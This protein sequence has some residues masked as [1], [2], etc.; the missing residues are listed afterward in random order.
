ML[1][2]VPFVIAAALIWAGANVYAALTIGWFVLV[3]I[4]K[5]LAATD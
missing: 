2:A 4:I 3:M 5:G 1:A